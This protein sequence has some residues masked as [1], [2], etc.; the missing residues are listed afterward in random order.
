M[1]RGLH[2]V[3]RAAERRSVAQVHVV[4]V[5]DGGI[6]KERRRN[7]IDP[8]RYFGFPRPEYLSPEQ[9]AGRPVTA[10]EDVKQDGA[11]IISLVIIC[12]CGRC[13]RIESPTA[14]LMI[15]QP[16][17]GD[18]KIE[19]LDALR[20]KGAGELPIAANGVLPGARPCL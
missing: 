14:R 7:D 19:N 12:F 11:R 4:E 5:L 16:R 20:A 2:G 9:A 6:L 8:F 13:Q 1:S 18:R 15:E 10:H 3:P 17:P